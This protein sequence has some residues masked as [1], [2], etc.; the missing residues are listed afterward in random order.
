MVNGNYTNTQHAKTLSSSL[1]K[2]QYIYVEPTTEENKT[3]DIYLGFE[4][5]LEIGTARYL[6]LEASADNGSTWST[7]EVVTINVTCV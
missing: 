6:I 7:I 1:Q 5:I 2:V 3:Q 4:N